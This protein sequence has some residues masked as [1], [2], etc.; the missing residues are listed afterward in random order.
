MSKKLRKIRK[1]AYKVYSQTL[2]PVFVLAIT[3][4]QMTFPQMA[5]AIEDISVIN[6]PSNSQITNIIDYSTWDYEIRLPESNN[7]EPRYTI[8]ITVTAYN[9][10]PWQTDDTPC[11]A[12]SGMDVCE[13]DAEDIIATNFAH[14]PFGT[15]VKLPDLYGDRIFRVEDR[16]NKR[17]YQRADIWM[18]D[19]ADAKA[20]GKK[21]T[22]MEIF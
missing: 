12:A 8:N 5:L 10:L 14:L 3:A 1:K 15:R 17:Y 11:I 20:F 7:K 13:R 22:R 2:I 4:I 18:K 21:Y 6:E 19:Y 9:S 16:M